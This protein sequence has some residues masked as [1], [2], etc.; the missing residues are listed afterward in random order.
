MKAEASQPGPE[1]VLDR[2]EELLAAVHGTPDLGNHKDP[3]DELIFILLTAQTHFTNYER[4]WERLKASYAD[5]DAVAVA[6]EE[7]IETAIADGGLGRQKARHLKLLL[8]EIRRRVDQ[9]E[10]PNQPLSLSFLERWKDVRVEDFLRALPGIGP[11]TARCVMLYTLGRDTCPVDTH[12]FRILKR[13]GILGED[14]GIKSSHDPVEAAAPPRRRGSLHINLVAHGRE[15]CKPRTPVCAA[16]PL[17]SFCETG[18]RNTRALNSG[19][20]VIDL[21]SGAGGLSEGF[22]KA[23]YRI[24]AAVELDRHAAQSF[25]LNFPGTLVLEADLREVPA[26][27]L[28]DLTGLAPGD[29]SVLCAG[30][31]CQGYSEAGKRDASDPQNRLFEEFVRIATEVQPESIVLENVE[32]LRRRMNAHFERAVLDA[33][34]VI[35]P[36]PARGYHIRHALLD[37]ADFGVPQHRKR[38]IY[39][40]ARQD[41][42]RLPELPTGTHADGGASTMQPG[43][44]VRWLLPRVTVADVLKGL[45]EIEA[46]E[47]AEVL[48]VNGTVFYNHRAMVHGEAVK[49]KIAALRPGSGPI[50]YRK[51]SADRPAHTVTAGHSAL[52][53]HPWI[54]R[55]I[56]VREAARLQTFEDSFRFLGPRH[57]QALQVANAVPPQFAYVL[58]LCAKRLEPGD[59]RR[60][61]RNGTRRNGGSGL[62]PADKMA[63]RELVAQGVSDAEI[64]SRM[65]VSVSALR[66]FRARAGIP[67]RV[68]SAAPASVTG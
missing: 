4:T 53:A 7:E 59:A 8:A 62:G 21:F 50:S 68:S 25:R 23:G 3:L 58:A 39:V 63:V 34:R 52:P 12:V 26:K 16:C 65:C 44:E 13:M 56:T 43:D 46:G 31:P 17:V 20:A 54:P 38:M 40:A 49:G 32:G 67:R 28:L 42:G 24:A 9:L 66:K 30:P 10:G 19:P 22:R 61:G 14:V 15:I 57:A 37:V 2:V 47:G 29:L 35:Q 1:E 18:Q 51:L 41:L 11:K 64:A 36:T 5:W 48:R 45:P 55:S 6:P 33:L 27:V 60:G